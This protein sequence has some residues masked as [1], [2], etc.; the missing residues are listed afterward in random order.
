MVS[1]VKN[2]A[3]WCSSS[4]SSPSHTDERDLFFYEA[5]LR[6]IPSYL[7]DM[8]SVSPTLAVLLVAGL[9]FICGLFLVRWG[10]QF[11]LLWLIPSKDV[12]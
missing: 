11:L 3:V 4:P 8:I 2:S 6:V 10:C 1:Y 7:L 12:L 5:K 9:E